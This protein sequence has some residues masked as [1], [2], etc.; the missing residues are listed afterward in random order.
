VSARRPAGTVKQAF[1]TSLVHFVYAGRAGFS[2]ASTA[3]GPRALGDIVG[4]V[5]GQHTGA[6]ARP[7]TQIGALATPLALAAGT[8]TGHNP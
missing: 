8:A 7:P 2:N 1:N 4:S 3:H 6:R 5:L